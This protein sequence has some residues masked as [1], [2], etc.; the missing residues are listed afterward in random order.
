MNCNKKSY[1]TKWEAKKAL[2]SILSRSDKNPWRD[3]LSIYQCDLC[4]NKYH[5]SSKPGEYIPS[6]I[7][8]MTYYDIQKE[9]WGNLTVQ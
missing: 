2:F 9:K 4:K 8:D 1:N 3:E 5:I 6:K 7:K